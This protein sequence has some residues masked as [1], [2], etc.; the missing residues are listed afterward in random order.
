MT[1]GKLNVEK[2]LPIRTSKFISSKDD[3]INGV[4]CPARA[5]ISDLVAI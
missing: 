5:C 3:F 4:C 2:A 1:E